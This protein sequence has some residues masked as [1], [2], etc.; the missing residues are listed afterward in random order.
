MIKPQY[1]VVSPIGDARDAGKAPDSH[2]SAPPLADLKGKKLGLVW[3]AF[4]NG[5]IVLH[6]FREHLTRRHPE[7]A[8]V[9]MAPGRNLQWGDHPDRTIAEVAREQGIDAAIITAG[10]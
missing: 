1:E 5:D 3:T 10:C 6:A 9:E 7:L 4:S 8:F 2:A